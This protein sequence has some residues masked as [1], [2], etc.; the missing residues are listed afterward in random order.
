MLPC[1]TRAIALRSADLAVA[2]DGLSPDSAVWPSQAHG[3]GILG[4]QFATH[5]SRIAIVGGNVNRKLHPRW[6]G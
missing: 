5:G 2:A 6:V 3:T 4:G 1:L